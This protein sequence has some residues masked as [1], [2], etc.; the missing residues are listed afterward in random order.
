MR[1]HLG[2][3]TLFVLIFLMAS[4]VLWWIRKR[5]KK[6]LWLPIL[7]VLPKYRSTFPKWIFKKPPL[8]LFFA[9]LL[10]T[11]PLLWLSFFPFSFKKTKL[12]SLVKHWVIVLDLSPSTSSKIEIDAYRY[13]VK[14][15]KQ[16]LQKQKGRVRFL[17]SGEEKIFP[18]NTSIETIVERMHFHRDGLKL[19][20]LITH[21]RK[22]LDK[23]DH[24][25]ILSD[26][27]HFSW[28]GFQ[29]Q[30]L[31]SMVS[32]VSFLPLFSDEEKVNRANVF[33]H[34]VEVKKNEGLF[35]FKV[36]LQR[37]QTS[38]LGM[39]KLQI[40][41]D[42]HVLMEKKWQFS[43]EKL[44]FSLSLSLDPSETPIEQKT[45]LKAH[46]VSKNNDALH[47]DNDFYFIFKNP[48]KTVMISHVLRGESIIHSPSYPL[49]AALASLG[50]SLKV[51]YKSGWPAIQ[52]WPWQIFFFDDDGSLPVFC[53]SSGKFEAIS[54][55]F[56]FAPIGINEGHRKQCE[57]WLEFHHEYE[58]SL[59]KRQ[60]LCQNV[61][62][63]HTL[64][65]LFKHSPAK[66]VGGTLRSQN[67][68]FAWTFRQ[69]QQDS[70]WFT[71][72]LRPSL[73]LNHARFPMLIKSLIKWFHLFPSTQLE[74][75]EM[76]LHSPLINV[77]TEESLL[78]EYSGDLP[79]VL[80]LKT[81]WGEK[82]VQVEEGK[83]EDASF[84]V[85]VSMGLFFCAI[86]WELFI[87][88]KKTLL[89]GFVLIG[90]LGFLPKVLEA[91][92][93]LVL[94]STHPRHI[95]VGKQFVE[96]YTSIDFS[97]E[98]RFLPSL[99]SQLER[100][101]WVWVERRKWLQIIESM[102][103]ESL[104]RFRQWLYQGGLLIIYGE[105]LPSKTIQ[106]RLFK[107]IQGSWSSISQNHEL[108]RSFFLI[109]GLPRC[110]KDHWQ[111]FLADDRMMALSIPFDILSFLTEKP[112]SSCILQ[113][114]NVLRAF[115]NTT[116][117]ALTTDYKKDQIHLKEILKRRR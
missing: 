100:Y 75:S 49:Q 111:G 74:I 53:S 56:W 42:H 5:Q 38:S 21:H 51:V 106:S 79:P 31:R 73:K 109:S 58:G 36:R 47:A 35:D 70:V 59:E 69:S 71:L 76:S 37:N 33:V 90:G 25:L 82:S 89:L 95:P 67:S 105:H 77:V 23:K 94:L 39:G 22:E 65:Q 97:S 60:K 63:Q 98:V 1:L 15:L 14:Q 55:T 88:R 17:I 54:S 91:R 110:H 12:S 102:T 93:R 29:W 62:N 50:F 32:G 108:M 30:L 107:M 18:E 19:G 112:V 61:H 99:S 113:R 114:E 104:L 43:P 81:L 26:R 87:M 84:W 45:V 52:E 2:S 92:V 72:P 4:L 66:P 8:G 64:N 103:Q 44:Y 83:E 115:T 7:A 101:S 13:R 27:D 10:V 24:L 3:P 68:T 20:N 86:F 57:C 28:E 85:F 78:Q 41:H 48:Q 40:I 16:Q 34:S 9:F 11:L 6:P 96:K 46:L 80:D 117:V 116:M